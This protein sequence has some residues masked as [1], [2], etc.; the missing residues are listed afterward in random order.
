MITSSSPVGRRGSFS[1][2]P[3]VKADSAR[4]LMQTPLAGSGFKS[5]KAVSHAGIFSNLT[6]RV[7]SVWREF[8]TPAETSLASSRLELRSQRLNSFG[9]YLAWIALTDDFGMW[10][11]PYLDWYINEYLAGQGHRFTA[12]QEQVLRCGI[13]RHQRSL[14]LLPR[15][16]F[17]SNLGEAAENNLKDERLENQAILASPDSDSHQREIA[18]LKIHA[19]DMFRAAYELDV[20]QEKSPTGAAVSAVMGNNKGQSEAPLPLPRGEISR[21]LMFALATVSAAALLT[22]GALAFLSGHPEAV[23]TV[24]NLALPVALSSVS[25]GSFAKGISDF[26]KSDDPFWSAMLTLFIPVMSAMFAYI[27]YPYPLQ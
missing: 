24:Q 7:G 9:D 2:F 18:Q 1:F 10:S 15:H 23:Q 16:E 26:K 14:Y 13:G 17:P 12:S 20:S 6:A 25:L 22:G 3:F 8:W 5:E 27:T 19:I 11:S 4:P 21:P